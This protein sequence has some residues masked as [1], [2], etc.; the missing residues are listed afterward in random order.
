MLIYPEIDPVIVSI[1]PLAVR[2]Y[3]LMYLLGLA[4]AWG[5]TLRG[6]KTGRAPL[7]TREQADDLIFYGALGVIFGGRIG[8]TLFYQFDLFLHN[9]LWLFKITQGG[10]S[11]HGGLLGVIFALW[12]YARKLGVRF[13]TLMDFVAPLVPIGLGLGR[14]GNFINQELWGRAASPDFPWAMIF[15][16][17]PLQLAR[18]PSQLY[19]FALEGV[20]L[21][22]LLQLIARRQWPTGIVSGFFLILYALFRFAVEF[23]REPDAQIGLDWLG[24]MTRGQELCIPMFMA[25]IAICVWSLRHRKQEN[26]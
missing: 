13:F 8:Y 10:M 19:Q 9:P 6:I 16:A 15:P 1:G 18:H 24:W 22:V 26:N 3:G 17:D 12:L 11:F 7:Q 25:G 23:F 4:G 14:L 21:F 2:W 20:A 5:L